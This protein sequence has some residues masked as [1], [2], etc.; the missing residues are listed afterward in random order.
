MLRARAMKRVDTF[1]VFEYFVERSVINQ[2]SN[3]LSNLAPD[4]GTPLPKT[5]PVSQATEHCRDY[6]F[7]MW[8][9]DSSELECETWTKPQTSP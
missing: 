7:K 8:E 1:N 6:F 3:V 9:K 2:R 4:H 5:L